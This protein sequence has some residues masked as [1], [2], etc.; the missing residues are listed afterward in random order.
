MVNL[1]ISALIQVALFSLV[2]VIVWLVMRKTAKTEEGFFSWIGLKPIQTGSV[3]WF[4]LLFFAIFAGVCLIAV[5][6]IPLIMRESTSATTQF[7]GEGTSAIPGILIYAVIQTGLSEEILFRGFIGKR[8]I[9]RLGF[10]VGNL[11]QAALFGLMHGT[12]FLLVLDAPR[13]LALTLITGAIGWIEGWINEKKAG[14]SII[15]SWIFHSL[16]NIASGL[17]AA[18]LLV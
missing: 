10:T 18:F 1:L 13:A 2:P 5:I 3:V 15:P 14:G 17:G 4:W 7:K 11:I 9:A 8:C 12:L 16:T 6:V